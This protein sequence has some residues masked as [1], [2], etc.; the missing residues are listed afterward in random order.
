MDYP[1]RGKNYFIP[2]SFVFYFSLHATFFVLPFLM[3]LCSGAI[4]KLV[5]KT[6]CCRYN[7][8]LLYPPPAHYHHHQGRG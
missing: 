4:F 3:S 6:L 8:F 2:R 7:L 1:T 5:W